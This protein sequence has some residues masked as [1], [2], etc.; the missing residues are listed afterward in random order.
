MMRCLGG[1]GPANTSSV[2][3]SFIV[4]GFP[5]IVTTRS[6]PAST[7]GYGRNP[8]AE[9]FARWFAL[10]AYSPMM[11]ILIGPSRTPWYSYA[12]GANTTPPLVAVARTFTQD[13][14]DLIPSSARSCITRP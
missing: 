12:A 7:G 6:L 3:F 1:S 14:H 5:P 10:S 13:H 9:T 11:E 4:I 2:S 8:S